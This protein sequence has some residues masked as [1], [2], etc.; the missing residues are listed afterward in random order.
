MT[1]E[2]TRDAVELSAVTVYQIF[3]YRTIKNLNP[4]TYIFIQANSVYQSYSLVQRLNRIGQIPLSRLQ[5]SRVFDQSSPLHNC[6]A[7]Y[8]GLNT[9]RRVCR[10]QRKQWNLNVSKT[11]HAWSSWSLSNGIWVLWSWTQQC[12]L[13]NLLPVSK[14]PYRQCLNP[15]KGSNSR[16]HIKHDKQH[17]TEMTLYLSTVNIKN[18]KIMKAESGNTTTWQPATKIWKQMIIKKKSRIRPRSML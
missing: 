8:A 7:C 4:T 1:H 3:Q 2:I 12:H 15:F 6:Y 16:A 10:V 18:K 9:A 5:L 13:S 11:W 17:L 14:I